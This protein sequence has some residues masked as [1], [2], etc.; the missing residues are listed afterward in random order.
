M[1]LFSSLGLC[2]TEGAAI[3]LLGSGWGPSSTL[4]AHDR[5]D[6]SSRSIGHECA[7]ECVV[8]LL[9]QFFRFQALKTRLRLLSE[10]GLSGSRGFSVFNEFSNKVKGQAKRF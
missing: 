5:L 2:S 4:D 3:A 10:N 6:M 1:S 7:S 9:L 8:R